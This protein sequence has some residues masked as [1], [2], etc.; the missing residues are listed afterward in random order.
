M[1]SETLIRMHQCGNNQI[2]NALVICAN[3]H[4]DLVKA[5]ARALDTKLTAIILEPCTRNTAAVGAIAAAYVKKL[6][7]RGITN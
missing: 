6:D 7:L 4:Q 2:A 5:Q 3:G 1:F